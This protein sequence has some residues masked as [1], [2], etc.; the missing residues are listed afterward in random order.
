MG[1][2]VRTRPAGRAGVRVR[3]I[4]V[5]SGVTPAAHARMAVL[6]SILPLPAIEASH[7]L[8]SLIGVGLLLLARALQRRVGAAYVLTAGLLAGGCVFS[9]TKGVDFEEALILAVSLTILLPCRRHFYLD[10]GMTP[11]KLGEEARVDLAAFSLE[12]SGSRSER[13]TLHRLEREGYTFD[14][15]DVASVPAVL[16][17]FR[18]ISSEWLAEKNTREKSFSLGCFEESYVC[19]FSHAVVRKD[20]SIFAFANL[21]EGG[22][23]EELSIDL[24]RHRSDAPNGL[25]DF[26]FL[27]L[28][29]YGK[30]HGYRWF[31]LG[32]A[33]FSGFERHVQ[34]PMWN[35]M[36]GL[37]FRHGEHFYN[38][39]GL[40]QYKEKFH[41]TW[42][43]KY[44]VSPAG[45]ALPQILANVANLILGGLA[46][47]VKK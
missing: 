37:L 17:E 29:L 6:R 43:P 12:G 26:L 19:Q 3:A 23:L 11:L 8:A 5:F 41:P 18:S 40:R 36:A 2:A 24:M 14:I 20:N 45:I 35:R 46:G 22:Q 7:F 16:A 4:L 31:S 9:L 33:P 32:M 42:S 13:N 47:A 34:A 38:F 39:Q 21:W 28:L 1:I 15:I 30:E 44:L 27:H 25:M 10:L